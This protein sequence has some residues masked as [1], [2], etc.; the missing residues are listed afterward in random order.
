MIA[1]AKALTELFAALPEIVKLIQQIQKQI[2][3][4]GV[5]RKVKDDL[6]AINK[7]FEEKDARALSDIFNS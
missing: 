2:A 1:L 5:E 6:R 7:A 3:A 4:D